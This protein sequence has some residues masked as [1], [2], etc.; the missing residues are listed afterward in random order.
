MGERDFYKIL[1]VARGASEGEIRKAYRDLARKHHP[2]R[3]PGDKQAE[4]KFKEVSQA[5]DVL[6]NKKKRKLYDEFGE[7][8]LKEGFNADA[9]RHYQRGATA[10]GAGRGPSFEDLF[11][12]RTPGGFGGFGF[13]FG[14]GSVED[15]LR[16]ARR[17]A[18]R[19]QYEHETA[20]SAP[21][22]ISEMSLGFVDALRGGERSLQLSIPGQGQREL[23]VR[24][25]AGVKDGGQIRLRGQGV[26][27][28]DLVIKISVEDHPVFKRDEDDLLLGL[29]ITVGEAFR[30]A[31]IAVPTPEGDVTL[32]VP[33]G[34]KS[35]AKLRLRG[36]GIKVG[37]RV[38]DLIVTL[39][40]R[41]P[42][43]GD[44]E[45][46]KLVAE[47]DKKYPEDLRAG[48]KL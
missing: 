4:E 5:S 43:T 39:L 46:E 14:G 42:E 1:G 41:L 31:K 37:G 16:G 28:G 32:S 47:L 12:G 27:G 22:V 40:I 2:D 6:L 10:G 13:D 9:F 35:G 7:M 25:P 21:D 19:E 3:N 23:R 33:A 20:A 45:T 26:D 17:R 15:I 36:K 18:Q 24:I 29:P 11:S 44:A 48:L 34:A 38:G 30:G 8:G